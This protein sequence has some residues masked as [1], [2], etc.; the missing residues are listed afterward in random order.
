MGRA[1]VT[2][3]LSGRAHTGIV[4]M[5]PHAGDER[6]LLLLNVAE[7]QAR[8]RHLSGFLSASFFSDRDGRVL[9]EF[10]QWRSADHVEAAFREPA[11]HEHLP[12]VTT[13][14]PHPVIAF[15]PPA[16]V[17]TS[18]GEPRFALDHPRY[19]ATVF[20]VEDAD[21]DGA[22]KQVVNWARSLLAGAVDA[23]VILGDRDSS[24]IGG[25]LAGD[26]VELPMPDP[27]ER[28]VVV[29]HVGALDLYASICA[30]A[31]D[32]RPLDYVMTTGQ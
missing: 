11:F 22:L 14:A 2:V 19:A 26:F 24:L 31:K 32:E 12:V 16:A 29:E 20:R 9:V 23:A 7:T 30:S 3:D 1:A 18:R 4:A 25:F 21:F 8:I 10:L 6:G 13:M 28:I 5:R 15:G 17:L 27:G